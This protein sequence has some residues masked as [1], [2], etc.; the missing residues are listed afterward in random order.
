[1]HNGSLH[2][3]V[4]LLLLTSISALGN[5]YTTFIE[6]RWAP[7]IQERIDAH[8]G[9]VREEEPE[10]EDT[11]PAVPEGARD[12]YLRY[13][14]LGG[15]SWGWIDDPT[16]EYWLDVPGEPRGQGIGPQPYPPREFLVAAM[17]GDVSSAKKKPETRVYR[18]FFSASIVLLFCNCSVCSVFIHGIEAFAAPYTRN[19]VIT[20]IFFTKSRPRR[21]RPF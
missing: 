1:M 11:G 21:W 17:K 14:E 3:M 9:V 6:S 10:E 20:S 8:D 19:A 18:A 5:S 12:F 2:L 15:R 4:T 16:N 13:A 7:D